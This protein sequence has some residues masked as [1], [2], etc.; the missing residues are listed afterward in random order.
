VVGALCRFVYERIELQRR[1]ALRNVVTMM[2]DANGS[3]EAISTAIADYLARSVF[4]A[5][6]R[7]LPSD[8]ARNAP[9]EWWKL[10][11]DARSSELA[12][13]LLGATSRFLE[14]DPTH[15]GY[16][17]LASLMLLTRESPDFARI[18]GNLAEAIANVPGSESSRRAERVA[19]IADSIMGR[20]ANQHPAKLH[21][22]VREL[23]R[24][25]DADDLLRAAYP[26]VVDPDLRKQCAMPWIRKFSALSTRFVADALGVAE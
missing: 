2:E 18:A 9:E 3:P 26:H 13:R 24:R 20:V 8:L 16:R 15:V 14:S 7:A 19:A 21:D 5:R 10:A 22:L 11:E 25:D 17:V 6:L 1:E 23:A 4:T 12:M